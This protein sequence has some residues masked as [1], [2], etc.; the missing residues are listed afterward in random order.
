MRP[1]KIAAALTMIYGFHIPQL[2]C[3][4]E[5]LIDGFDAGPRG[6]KIPRYMLTCR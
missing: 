6:S 4:W 2:A 5:L 1:N 3:A